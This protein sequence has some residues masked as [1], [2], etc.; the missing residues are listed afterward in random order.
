MAFAENM[1]NLPTS[2]A[3]LPHT[4]S[5]AGQL[6]PGQRLVPEETAIA[7][8]YNGASHA[9]MMATPADLEDFA[10]G[11]SLTEGIVEAVE[12]IFSL[13]VV[14]SE[15]GVELRMWIRETRMKP[16]SIRRRRL[17]GPTGCGLCGIE[18]LDEASRPARRVGG[19]LR[20]APEAI[21]AAMAALPPAQ[22]LNCETRAVHAAAFWQPHNGIV[23]VR[24]DVGRHNALDK[25]IGSL[26][27]HR[28]GGGS[29]IVL[30][31]SRVSVEMVQKTAILGASILVAV[32]A[33]TALAVRVAEACGMT[34]VAIARGPDFE[35]FSHPT[36]IAAPVVSN[37]VNTFFPGATARCRRGQT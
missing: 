23:A 5:R 15:L 25:L 13:E 33:P 30:L 7:F 1:P 20:L 16:Y 6:I 35:V 27:R 18:S 37:S 12:D 9:V 17:A 14:G 11:L 10:A 28:I 19:G 21:C 36:R 31:T 22:L 3:R 32:S 4:A 24:E 29:G 34:L 26:A 8:T 2:A